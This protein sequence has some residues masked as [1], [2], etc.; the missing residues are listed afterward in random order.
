MIPAQYT[1]LSSITLRGWFWQ[2]AALLDQTTDL[3][4]F[5]PW[6][7]ESKRGGIGGVIPSLDAAL[8]DSAK[9]GLRTPG[10]D[11]A[12]RG[13]IER[14]FSRI[15]PIKPLLISL[16]YELDRRFPV[17]L[18]AVQGGIRQTLPASE[19]VVS[20]LNS[21]VRFGALNV[22]YFK[23]TPPPKRLTDIKNRSWAILQ[24]PGL[25]DSIAKAS[26]PVTSKCSA[27]Q[28]KE[29]AEGVLGAKGGVCTTFAAAAVHLLLNDGTLMSTNPRI[30]FV[31]GPKHCLCLVNRAAHASDVEP[32]GHDPKG[33]IVSFDL[34]ND[35]VVII[36]PWAGSMGYHVISNKT[37][38]PAKLKA[39]VGLRVDK[40]Y[41]NRW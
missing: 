5:V 20:L 7:T 3:T 11:G 17:A 18:P 19:Q 21:M 15:G 4:E 36:D 14:G 33:T 30:E 2:Q 13:L 41:D 24:D 40:Y 29:M 6:F 27:G 9:R 12:L 26:A 10:V 37:T 16:T 22:T 23:D 31:S 25:Q 39:M 35:D 28:M 34:W 38:Y 1:N 8:E 32:G